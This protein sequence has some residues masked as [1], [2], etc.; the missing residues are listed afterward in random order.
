[1]NLAADRPKERRH[2]AAIA[3]IM[4]GNFLPA[5]LSRR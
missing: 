5:A 1:M 3:A 2:L 4:T